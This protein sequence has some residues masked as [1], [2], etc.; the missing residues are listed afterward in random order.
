MKKLTIIFAAITICFGVS[1]NAFA[2]KNTGAVISTIHDFDTSSPSREFNIRSDSRNFCGTYEDPRNC[3]LYPYYNKVESVESVFQ[4][5]VGDWVLNTLSSPTRRA[6]FDFGNATYNGKP[7]TGYYPVRFITQC[8][9]YLPSLMSVGAT[10]TCPVIINLDH[11]PGD[12]SSNLSLRFWTRTDYPEATSVTW[13]CTSLG[14]DN[15]CNGW[16]ALSSNDNK[17]TAQLLERKIIKNKITDTK[18]APYSF[19]FEISIAK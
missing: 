6:F 19:S 1:I 11:T 15:K 14:S 9:T 18:I 3:S 4:G 5:G 12:D 8:S 13:T 16:Q 7:L 2:Q 10:T 17:L